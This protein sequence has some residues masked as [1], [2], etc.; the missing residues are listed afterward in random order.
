MGLVPF[1]HPD[2]IEGRF[3]QG[4]CDEIGDVAIDI[5]I[6]FDDCENPCVWG[7]K[8]ETPSEHEEIAKAIS[9][10]CRES[11]L[12]PTRQVRLGCKD[13]VIFCGY[14]SSNVFSRFARASFCDRMRALIGS[15]HAGVQTQ[16]PSVDLPSSGMGQPLQD[17]PK[18]ATKRSTPK[19]HP[20]D[21]AEAGRIEPDPE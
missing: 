5:T 6:R 9:L 10:I 19:T 1:H 14:L 4:I 8:I 7:T 18:K 15:S 13:L 3:E 16:Q 20:V 17:R 11:F 2:S 12:G 21:G